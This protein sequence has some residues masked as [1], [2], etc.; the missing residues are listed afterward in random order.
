MGGMYQLLIEK[1]SNSNPAIIIQSR[2]KVVSLLNTFDSVLMFE[3]VCEIY[4]W[5]IYQKLHNSKC[6]IYN[7]FFFCCK[8]IDRSKKFR[9]YFWLTRFSVLCISHTTT[10]NWDVELLKLSRFIKDKTLKINLRSYSL[11]KTS[12]RPQ[13][14]FLVKLKLD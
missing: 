14:S 10:H 6:H 13:Y 5:R 1:D 2:K 4:V 11:K 7:I 3:N 12:L 9:S 8:E